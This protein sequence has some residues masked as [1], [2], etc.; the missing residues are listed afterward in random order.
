MRREI[1]LF[2]RLSIF[3]CT[4]VCTPVL[5]YMVVTIL[6]FPH[7]RVR[8]LFH[9]CSLVSLALLVDAIIKVAN[10]FCA[11]S[12][13]RKFFTS[14]GAE[15][16][17]QKRGNNLVILEDWPF[18]KKQLVLQKNLSNYWTVVPQFVP[19]NGLHADICILWSTGTFG[20]LF[21]GSLYGKN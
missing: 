16:S 15:F 9:T 4:Y 10:N 14:K 11:H 21:S 5:L 7:C 8:W 18:W 17:K 2:V 13:F 19:L 12:S 20:F 3:G 6:T 1:P